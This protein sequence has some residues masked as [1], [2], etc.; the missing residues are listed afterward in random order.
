MDLQP[1]FD[2]VDFAGFTKDISYN[3]KYSLGANI[4][5]H[6]LKFR[7]GNVKNI[8]I[9]IV[10][11]PFVSKD[12]DCETTDV[13]DRIRK[14]IYQ[15][16]GQGKLN[17]IDFGNLKQASS[18]KGNYLALRDVVDYLNELGAVTIILGGSQDFS[19]GVSQAYR[20]NKFFSFCSVDA[21]LD[22]KKG[23]EAFDPTNYLSRI[24]NSQPNVFQFS[25]LGYQSHYVPAEYFAKIRGINTNIRLGQLRDDI[26]IAEPVFR[27]SDFLSF[28]FAALKHTDA[29]GER[30]LPNGLHSE[31]ACQLAKYAGL[32]NRLNV[33]G[34]FGISSNVPDSEISVQL[35]A[36][37]VWYFIEGYFNRSNVFPG[38]GD[39][40]DVNKVEI[41]ELNSPLTFYKNRKTN[42][43]W[44]EVQSINNE[45]TY[46]ACDE[47][48]Y[49]EACNN[50][51]PDFWL[52]YIQKIDEL[53]K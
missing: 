30:K 37:M 27:N 43:W 5:K 17:I 1:Y 41:A 22:V 35:A 23:K 50:E 7:N 40:F 34:L 49:N 48:D 2:V 44:I 26:T 53:L 4:E 33:V 13:P 16:A 28:D 11:V 42:Q 52:K 51:I 21:F 9:A 31:E 46:I 45:I 19:Y 14:E 18:H 24:F 32:S 15:L 36:Q 39:G 20:N 6:T 8:E 12:N 10:G 29:P 38:E 47:R 25:L 3:W